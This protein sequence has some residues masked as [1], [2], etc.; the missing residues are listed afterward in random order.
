MRPA[1]S[2]K[3]CQPQQPF[4]TTLSERE[5]FW[6]DDLE[7]SIYYPKTHASIKKGI[8]AVIK[9]LK[10]II[11]YKKSARLKEIRAQQYFDYTDAAL[12][13]HAKNLHTLLS[14]YPTH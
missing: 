7:E 2:N 10:R 6:H 11:R 9:E 1:M 14:N 8:L 12:L 4:I 13:R 3:V 5:S